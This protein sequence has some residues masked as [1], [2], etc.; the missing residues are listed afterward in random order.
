MDIPKDLRTQEWAPGGAIRQEKANT[1]TVQFTICT[2][3][4]LGSYNLRDFLSVFRVEVLQDD[5]P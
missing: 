1:L 4:K 3:D 5:L 2:Q